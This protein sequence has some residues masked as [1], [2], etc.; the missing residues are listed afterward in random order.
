MGKSFVVVIHSR[1][2]KEEDMIAIDAIEMMIELTRGDSA[3]I[4]FSAVN[5]DGT[6]YTPQSG[7]VLKFAVANEVGANPVF[8]IS[9]TYTTST[10]TFWTVNIAPNDTADLDF[11]DYVWDLQI[12]SGNNVTTIIGKTDDLSPTFRVWGE[13][14]QQGE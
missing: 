13:V 12:E 11:G 4:V 6:T 2:R 14:A 7:D 10:E 3:S 1:K 9:N 8:V 5:E